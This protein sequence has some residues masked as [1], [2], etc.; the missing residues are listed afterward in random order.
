MQ[1]FIYIYIFLVCWLVGSVVVDGDLERTDS[2]AS[3]DQTRPER[4]RERE[5]VRESERE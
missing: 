1:H 2:I 4:E 5:R 3:P